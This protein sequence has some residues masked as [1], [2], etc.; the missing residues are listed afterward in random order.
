LGVKVEADLYRPE[1]FPCRGDPKRTAPLG[2]P[3]Y[4]AEVLAKEELIR[5]QEDAIAL[6]QLKE[7]NCTLVNHK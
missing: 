1:G 3:N 4:W 6:S 2:I 7:M 5:S